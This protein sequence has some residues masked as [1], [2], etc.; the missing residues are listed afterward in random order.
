MFGLVVDLLAVRSAG[1]SCGDGDQADHDVER[2][3]S[4]RYSSTRTSRNI[5]AA[6][7]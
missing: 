5:P 1:P 4:G 6:M 2:G 3:W 7:W